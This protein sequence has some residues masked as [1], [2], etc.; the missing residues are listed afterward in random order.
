MWGRLLTSQGFCIAFSRHYFRLKNF[1]T[2]IPPEPS[3]NTSISLEQ[4]LLCTLASSREFIIFKQSPLQTP[5]NYLL[6]IFVAAVEGSEIT[7]VMALLPLALAF[8]AFGI[9]CGGE[10]PP[11][12][13]CIRY[14]VDHFM[15]KYSAPPI[16]Q[17]TYNYIVNWQIDSLWLLSCTWRFCHR[18]PPHTFSIILHMITTT[19][20]DLDIVPWEV[21]LYYYV[22][23][24]QVFII[25]PGGEDHRQPPA[26]TNPTP[27][28][29]LD[30][31]I[32]GGTR[33]RQSSPHHI[34]FLHR[35]SYLRTFGSIKFAARSFL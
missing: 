33:Q 32:D 24:V 12:K 31:C 2:I 30:A 15:Q 28:T 7:L 23:S 6:S 10:C 3:Y 16:Q 14:Y 1:L 21:I 5:T 27:T 4:F 19:V 25:H 35:Q 29:N 20:Q 8:F 34:S 9:S 26:K 13:T 22:T 11:S 17:Q 18:W